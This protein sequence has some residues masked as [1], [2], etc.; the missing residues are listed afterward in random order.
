MDDERGV[1]QDN[2]QPHSRQRQNLIKEI[3]LFVL[4]DHITGFNSS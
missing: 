3:F 4:V 2:G 1:F